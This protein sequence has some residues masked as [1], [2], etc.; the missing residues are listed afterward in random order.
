VFYTQKSGTN[1]YCISEDVRYTSYTY[2]KPET[3]ETPAMETI[4]QYQFA[5]WKQIKDVIFASGVENI[6]KHAFD[7]CVSLK[8]VQLPITISLVDE[9]AFNNCTSLTHV[10]YEG[11]Y[12]DRVANI[13]VKEYNEPLENALWTYQSGLVAYRLNT[14]ADPSF[15]GIPNYYILYYVSPE[16]VGILSI[17]EV[18]RNGSQSEKVLGWLPVKAVD[19]NAAYNATTGDAATFVTDIILAPLSFAYLSDA[20][21]SAV[22]PD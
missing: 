13:D 11:D 3:I 19:P 12:F 9:Y 1:I 6:A 16:Y 5:G 7:N 18:W 2:E 22:S 8:Y 21:V 4:N 10:L 20:N 15:E 14:N 17:P